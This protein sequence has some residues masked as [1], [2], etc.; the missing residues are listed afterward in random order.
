MVQLARAPAQRAP[1][2]AAAARVHN[3]A[4][5]SRRA[6]AAAA[7]VRA[8]ATPAAVL[9]DLDNLRP[10]SASELPALAALI[11]QAV[12]ALPPAG[13]AAELRLT[14]VANVRTLAALGEADVA[15]ALAAAGGELLCTS[16]RS[17]A[18]DLAL[19][20]HAAEFVAAHG[21]A[22]A[23][24][25]IVSDDGDFAGVLAYARGRGCDAVAVGEHARRRRPAWAAPAPLCALALPRAAGAA[26]ALRRPRAAGGAWE[27]AEAWREKGAAAAVAASD[28]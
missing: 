1:P 18:V 4:A 19:R 5:A 23:R 10:A 2:A 12:A 7:R 13:D 21:A 11:V 3:A 8:A 27:V 25:A 22:G 26:I 9:W 6:A 24:L 15:A 28:L 14:A 17:Q 16:G 20:T